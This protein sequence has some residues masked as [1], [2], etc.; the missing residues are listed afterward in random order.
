MAR[1]TF[2]KRITSPE[3]IEQINP[4][5]KKLIDRFLRNFDTKRSDG[6]VKSYQSNFNI[7]FVWNVLYNENKFFVDIKKSELMDFFDFGV[8]ELKW[9]PNRYSQVWSSLSSLSN[10]I[11]MILDDD[12]PNF[13]NNIK[14]I[15][16]LPKNTVR[17]KSIF[18]KEDLDNLLNWLIEKDLHQEACLLSLA[19]S[20]GS[21]IS[22]LL[23]FTTDLIDLNNTAFDDLF[24]ETTE[25]MKVKGRG[26]AGKNIH[27]YIIKDMF[28]PHYLRWLP[29]REEIMRNSG[30][31]HTY[32]FIKNDGTPAKLSTVRSW[33][34]KWDRF[35]EKDWYPHAARHFWTTYLISIGCEE[36]FVKELQKWSNS[37]MVSI[38]NDLTAKD[39]KWKGLDKLKKHL[40]DNN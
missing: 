39:R 32:L 9:S 31:N 36:E 11:E 20:S 38:Y 2:K 21:R 29:I 40:Q 25:E 28:T 6:S 17:K 13:R 35:L 8:Q 30:L 3:L 18:T 34:T 15:E 4:K 5:N 14:K 23:R 12:Y 10:Y 24:L 19:M 27:R 33:M 16:K 1:A 22:E 7:F 37:E 26:K